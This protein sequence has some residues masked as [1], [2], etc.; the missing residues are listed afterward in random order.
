VGRREGG[1]R[2]PLDSRRVC[3]CSGEHAD[4]FLYVGEWISYFQTLGELLQNF[5]YISKL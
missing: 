5:A 1:E 2:G 4:P 3:I